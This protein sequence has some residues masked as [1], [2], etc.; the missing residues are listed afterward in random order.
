MIKST[1]VNV[2]I[3]R[4][5]SAFSSDN[6]SLHL[7]IGQR[8]DRNRCFGNIVRGVTLD[9]TDN[10]FL[11]FIVSLFASGRIWRLRQPCRGCIPA[12]LDPKPK[13]WLPLRLGRK[14][15][16]VRKFLLLF[17]LAG[18][19]FQRQHITDPVFQGLFFLLLNFKFAIESF[20][21]LLQ[22]ATFALQFHLLFPNIF[23][24]FKSCF[25]DL[26]LCLQKEFSFLFSP[27]FCA[28][29]DQLHCLC[30]CPFHLGADGFGFF[31]ESSR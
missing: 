16:Q 4:N 1:P 27:D 7:I 10:D 11:G 17:Q 13:F 22:T 31:A 2:S 23:F 28:S 8:N 30:F 26:L 5:I 24:Q 3:V 25:M 21:L 18:M 15:A 6:P 19:F 9:R 29:T 14:Y 20:L 12:W